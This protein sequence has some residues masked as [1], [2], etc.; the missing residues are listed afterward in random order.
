[1]KINWVIDELLS[2][3]QYET[4]FP[5][6]AD[7]AEEACHRVYRTKYVPFG[8][9]EDILVES[10]PVV[11]HG[12][13]QFN[14]KFE[15][16]YGK[17]FRPGMYFNQNVKSFEKFASKIGDDL[18][19]RNYYILPWGEIVRRKLTSVFVKPLSGLKEFPG[20]VIKGYDYDIQPNSPIPDDCLCVVDD[21]R[22]IK[23]E[24]RYVIA[25]RRVIT[26]SE[27]RW[28]N[29]LDVR[30]D[31]HP[32]CD[33]LAAKIAGADWQADIVYICDIALQK[34]QYAGEVAKVIELNAFS[35][36]GL[37]ACDTRKIIE[38]VSE[39]AY[40]EYYGVD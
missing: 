20:Q 26:G 33:K 6:L 15:K 32:V 12:T 7:A 1:M 28:D 18:L 24:F 16:K 30:T 31:T 17:L 8:E 13:I 36:S 19:N 5:T 38:A 25:N 34:F 37:Y 4:G 14:K 11:T 3:R 35:S 21:E 9:L 10:G 29:V 22:D 40:N 2:E 39:A 27:Y 23:A